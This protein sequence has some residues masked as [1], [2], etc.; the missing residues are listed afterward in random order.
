MCMPL[1]LDIG[2]NN[3]SLLND[4]LYMGLRQRRLRGDAYAELVE[5]F[6]MAVQERFPDA[7][8]QFEDFLT[9]NAYSLLNRYRDRVLCFN[10]DI[11]G[12]AAVA[13][14]GIYASTRL[15]GV[16]FEELKIMF[17][18]AGSAATGIADLVVKAFV[19]AGLTRREARERVWF[20][21]VNGLVVA[22]RE[23]LAEH[24][25][26]YAHEHAAAGFIESIESIKP[27]VLIGATGQPGTFTREAIERM[28]ELN[29]HPTI[30]ALSNPTSRA[31]C[32]PAQAYEWSG[33]KVIFASGSPFPGVEYQGRRYRPGQGNNVY[34]FP[35]VGLAAI[36]CKAERIT[37]EM[38]LVAART[39]AN[40]VSEDDLAAGAIYPPLTRIREIS[41]II[42]EAVVATA[43]KSGLARAP[44]VGDLRA[45]IAKAMYDP[46]Y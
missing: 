42:A 6:V 38:F 12:T 29:A 46:T 10:D 22:S 1:T 13:L 24:N 41:L 30:F 33:G 21:D 35:G 8:I 4:P 16:K 32:T 11:Q 40:L 28:S 3:E 36:A 37:E 31:E 14:A 27:N 34:V 39:L 45:T 17:L 2:T 7:L 18:G 44:I 9:P 43:Q 20:V 15:S 25:L 26:P 23:D 5:E 19:S